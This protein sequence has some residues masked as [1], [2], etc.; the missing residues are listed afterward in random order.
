MGKIVLVTGGNKGIGFGI[1]KALA[2]NAPEFDTVILTARN[3]ALGQQAILELGSPSKVVFFKLDVESKEDIDNCAS[4]VRGTYGKIDVLVNNAGWAAKGDAFDEEVVNTTIG[5]NFYGLKYM[6]EAFIPL[7]NESGHIVNI[8]SSCGETRFLKNENLALR[9]LDPNL[10]F[11]G[12]I[13]LAEEFKRL[14]KEGI[15]KENGWPTFGYAVS[16]ILVNSYTRVLNQEF[17]KNGINLRVN[18]V[19]PGWVRTDMAGQGADLSI[20]EGAALPVRVARDLSS[21]S[22]KYW[23]DNEHFEPY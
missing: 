10:T 14:V 7:L 22:G 13:G 21:L 17:V 15:W 16:K 6:T 1:V 3:P 20:E 2:L 23:R 18:A 19:H 9:F 5:I 12:I 8:S 4:F 11:E